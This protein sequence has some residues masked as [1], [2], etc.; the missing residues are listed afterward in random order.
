MMKTK[1]NFSNWIKL[2]IGIVGLA[3]V[4]VWSG[5]LLANKTQPDKLSH[6]PGFAVPED[7]ATFAVKVQPAPV[8]VEVVGSTASEEKINLSARI[9]AYVS[10]IFA[11]AGDRVKKGQVLMTLDDRDIKQKLAAAE[12][13]LSLAQT[14]YDRAKQLFERQAT[15]EQAMTAAESMLAGARAQVEEVK[16]M[17]T[18]A[19]VTSPIDGV[20]TDRRIEAGDLANPGMPLLAVYDPARMRLEAAIPVR[21]IDR[22]QLGQTVDVT[23][24]R[25]AGVVKGTVAEIVSEVDASSRTQIVK[26]KLDK[27]EGVLPGTFGRLWVESDARDA[28]LVPASAVSRI[29]Q[30]AFVQVVRDGRGLRRLVQVGAAQGDQVEILSGL[31][32]GDVILVNPVVEG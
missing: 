31:S 2:I 22:L 16:V 15:T 25:P 30:L 12:S 20:V 3:I 6:E 24:D 28:I 29:G 32:D 1:K 5:G 27:A 11:S 13:Q 23:L 7:A 9:P 17:L 10:E 19:Q 21:L 14:E 18:Y 26:V 4:V 8:R